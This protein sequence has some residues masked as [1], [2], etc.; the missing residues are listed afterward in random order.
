MRTTTATAATTT[1]ETGGATFM[2]QGGPSNYKS[3]KVLYLLKCKV[4]GEFCYVGKTK[5]KFRYGLDNYKS[6]YRAFR[7]GNRKIPYLGIDDWDFTLFEQCEAHNQLKKREN[8]W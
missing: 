3:E 7:K 2:I 8:V 4:Y 5:T 1:T 6:K